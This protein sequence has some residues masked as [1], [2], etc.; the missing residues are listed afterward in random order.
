MLRVV[1]EDAAR[2]ELALTLDEICATYPGCDPASATVKVLAGVTLSQDL[3][4]K[5]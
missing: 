1:V 4:V 3:P 2:H 5:C